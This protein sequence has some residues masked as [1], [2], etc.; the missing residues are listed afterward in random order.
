M[1]YPQVISSRLASF[2]RKQHLLIVEVLSPPAVRALLV[3]AARQI[4]ERYQPT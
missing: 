4:L 1:S 3:A 2:T